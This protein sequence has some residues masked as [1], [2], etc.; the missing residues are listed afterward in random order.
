MRDIVYLISHIVQQKVKK[1]RLK[2]YM[3]VINL[4]KSIEKLGEK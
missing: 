1:K 4:G 2:V 3:R